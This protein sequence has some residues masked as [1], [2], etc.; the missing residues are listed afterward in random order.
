MMFARPMAAFVLVPILLTIAFGQE[1]W[2][3]HRG[4][5]R[6]YQLTSNIDY[7]TQ[8]SVACDENIRWRMPLPETGHS[9][10]AV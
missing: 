4:P 7:P 2:P 8:W 9:G 1:K 5:Q 6:N 10:I 3:E